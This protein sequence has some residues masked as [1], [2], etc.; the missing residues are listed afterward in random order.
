MWWYKY[1]QKNKIWAEN[2]SEQLFK[3]LIEITEYEEEKESCKKFEEEKR[4]NKRYVRC[5]KEY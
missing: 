1:Q 3:G 2:G 5:S 4:K